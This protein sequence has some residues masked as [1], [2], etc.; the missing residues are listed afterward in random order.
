MQAPKQPRTPASCSPPDDA[1]LPPDGAPPPT[2]PQPSTFDPPPPDP[3]PP[4]LPDLPP[5][6]II[7]PA[8]WPVS[9]TLTEDGKDHPND[10]VKFATLQ[11]HA[12]YAEQ[13][14]VK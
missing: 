3:S 2:T 14:P 9:P 1:P 11:M 4:D 6:G 8:N 10:S 7:P 13:S 5:N 12:Y